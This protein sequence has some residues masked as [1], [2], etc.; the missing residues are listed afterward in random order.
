MSRI[1]QQADRYDDMQT[2][3]T[4]LILFRV[5]IQED[6]TKEERALISVGFKNYIGKF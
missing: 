5:N 1:A 2:Y 6:F 3:L 4:D